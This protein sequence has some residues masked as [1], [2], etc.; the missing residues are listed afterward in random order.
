L[1]GGHG[2]RERDGG[3]AET[4]TRRIRP[5]TADSRCQGCPFVGTSVR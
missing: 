5:T 1:A 3:R 4:G 2:D